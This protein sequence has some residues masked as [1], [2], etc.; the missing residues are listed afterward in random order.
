MRIAVL[1][2]AMILAAGPAHHPTLYD[3]ILYRDAQD[4]ARHLAAGADLLQMTPDGVPAAFSGAS[5]EVLRIL[6]NAGL[7]LDTRAPDGTTFFAH[8][9]VRWPDRP[10]Q[11]LLAA[12]WALSELQRA[13]AEIPVPLRIEGARSRVVPR[14]VLVP[15]EQPRI[16]ADGFT[17]VL[18]DLE[19]EELFYAFQPVPIK[20]LSFAPA[21]GC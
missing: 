16:A 1:A 14:R 19:L 21:T 10:A 2:G 18:A 9:V 15:T 7:A 4:V 12:G 8:Y 3:A 13:V 11:E 5:A 20:T 17:W 6:R